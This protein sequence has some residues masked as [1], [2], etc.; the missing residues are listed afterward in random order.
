MFI[1][2]GKKD[3][4]VIFFKMSS[5]KND[6]EYSILLCMEFALHW[7]FFFCFVL[8]GL[9]CLLLEKYLLHINEVINLYYNV[10]T[11]RTKNDA[12]PDKLE[13]KPGL[14]LDQSIDSRVG[15]TRDTTLSDLKLEIDDRRSETPFEMFENQLPPESPNKLNLEN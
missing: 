5:F 15:V 2:K 6:A 4:V 10:L 1:Q 7:G 3:G 14:Y 11:N 13:G 12:T 9:F 8:C